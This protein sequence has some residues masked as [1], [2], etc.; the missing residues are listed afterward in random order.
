MSIKNKIGIVLLVLLGI[1]MAYYYLA[2]SPEVFN[3]NIK[4]HLYFTHWQGEDG[5]REGIE[6][7]IAKYEKLHPDVRIHQQFQPYNG[8]EQ[9][10]LTQVLGGTAPDIME[11]S[12]VLA[13]KRLNARFLVPLTEYV[14]EENPYNPGL[15]WK[16]T[17]YGEMANL[18]D[19]RT[20]EYW[21][22]P[23]CMFTTRLY[24][25]KEIMKEAGL[26][27][28]KPFSTW[29]EF[30]EANKKVLSLKGKDGRPKY[31]AVVI[32]NSQ[33]RA[34]QMIFQRL[35]VQVYEG[36]NWD[37]RIDKQVPNDDLLSG[38]ELFK[39]IFRGKL[40]MDDPRL[41]EP[42]K[43]LKGYS[44]YWNPGFNGLS[45]ED[46]K[47][48]FI[49]GRAAMFYEGSWE[50]GTVKK[51]ASF[52]VGVIALPSLSREDTKFADVEWGENQTD[53]A[54]PFAVSRLA[55]GRG[56]LEVAIDF[57]RFMTSREN[58][59]LFAEYARWIPG[60]KDVPLPPEIQP[61]LPKM[62]G[63]FLW[64]PWSYGRRGR[65]IWHRNMQLYLAGDVDYK[66]FLERYRTDY[67]NFMK[68]QFLRDLRENER[69]YR[70]NMLLSIKFRIHSYLNRDN[71]RLAYK[72]A[73]KRI[74][75]E[76]RLTLAGRESFYRKSALDGYV[77]I[78]DYY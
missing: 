8:Y 23:Y 75:M 25:N 40:P 39:A 29:Q 9:W 41:M 12:Y 2:Q 76:E 31:L 15:K 46:A 33:P 47:F 3:P 34:D 32:P 44:R 43:L 10:I 62:R 67:V 7:I 65:D 61:F 26:N 60:V 37:E 18:E 50:F 74:R 70:R 59:A 19:P 56:N 63:K 48:A 78:S 58:M 1:Y 24:Y 16:D 45:L 38:P 5:V 73:L 66:T 55:E 6:A 42:F 13:Q 28:E 69:D 36:F 57:L 4:Y 14:N 77:D 54:M 68:K 53:P 20:L 21:T 72:Y 30:L 17:F 49:Q 71:A 51:G 52:E 11:Y 27:P 64:S 22:V 35:A